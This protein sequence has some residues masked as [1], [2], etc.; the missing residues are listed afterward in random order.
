MAKHPKL[1]RAWLWVGTI[2]ALA[3]VA[4]MVRYCVEVVQ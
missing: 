3:W 4:F 1:V 2:A